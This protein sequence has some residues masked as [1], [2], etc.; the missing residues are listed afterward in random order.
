LE[1]PPALDAMPPRL[2]IRFIV[3]FLL[4]GEVIHLRIVKLIAQCFAT[5]TPQIASVTSRCGVQI[6]RVPGHAGGS[7]GLPRDARHGRLNRAI[8]MID[9]TLRG[10][11]TEDSNLDGPLSGV[12]VLDL[13][14]IVA[15]PFATMALGEMGA[16]V[17]KVERSGAGDDSR[18]W[19][20]PFVNGESAYFLAVNRNKRS[21]SLD[22]SRVADQDVVR[23][24][25]TDW[26]DVVVE[27]FRAGTLD[28]W[29][30]SLESLRSANPRLVTATLTGYPPGD[31]RPGYDFIAQADTGVM[32]L[33]GEPDGA[34]YKVGYP[35]ADISAGLFLLSGLLAALYQR[36]RTGRG[37]HVSVSI[38]E[39]QVAVQV[40]V[41]QNFLV[42]RS[43]PSRLGNAHP[44]VAPYEMIRTS[45]GFIAVAVA[46]DR[47]FA[48]LAEALGLTPGAIDSRFDGNSGRV[49]NRAELIATVESATQALTAAATLALLR[50]YDIA[51]TQ[52]RT[53]DEVLA[54][55]EARLAG[56]IVPLKHPTIGKI[57]VVR[58]PWRFSQA[59]SLPRI[60]PPLLGEHSQAL[61][62]ILQQSPQSI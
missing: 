52:I 9:P 40:N 44:Q 37:Q 51:C 26:A 39:A 43:R 18:T 22:L 16:D 48:Q 34:P 56:T 45:D 36:E 10:D 15:A 24:L 58:L 55:E 54:S 61:Q 46:N 35:V 29:S 23:Q 19:G 7:A 60:P 8:D 12:R 21:L 47:Q 33:I 30:L 25:A 2:Y 38:W 17:L 14:R 27:N 53:I 62:A 13:S 4:T 31:T 59:S 6:T 41:N 28:R 3:S 50:R 49:A 57:D 1:T 32:S 5:S 20:P 42:T 11:V